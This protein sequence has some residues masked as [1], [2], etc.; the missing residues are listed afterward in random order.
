[1]KT[2]EWSPNRKSMALGLIKGGRHKLSE[3][4]QITNI[5][6]PTL[7]RIKKLDTAITK[8]RSGR[9]KK[10]TPR[11]LRH[12][13]IYIRSNYR[14]RRV[15]LSQL[16]KLFQLDATERTVRKALKELGYNHRVARR[17]PFLSKRDR[18][19]RLQF[20]KRHAHWTAED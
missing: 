19:R 1:M 8:P 9:P 4:T 5:P 14:T 16:I 7:R 20:A 17:R 15:R 11:D 10:L 18:K 6:S 3:I 2:H 12:I 13:E